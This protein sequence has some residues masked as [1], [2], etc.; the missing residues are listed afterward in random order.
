MPRAAWVEADLMQLAIVS[1]RVWPLEEPADEA[2]RQFRLRAE[3]AGR[4]ARGYVDAGFV[5][6]IDDIVH[7]RDRLAIYEEAVGELALVVL[8]PRFEVVYGRPE[9]AGYDEPPEWWVRLDGDLREG[10]D[11][12][13]LW[14]DTSEMT[15][16]ETA[17]A[18]AAEFL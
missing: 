18:V 17:D 8:V 2:Q 16:E 15:P 14:V 12:V 7:D 13:G 3:L 10:L 9:Y 4:L 1:G 5:P 6:V 11:G